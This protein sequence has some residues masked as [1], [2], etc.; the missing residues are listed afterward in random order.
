MGEDH[1]AV[2]EARSIAGDGEDGTF[3]GFLQALQNGR[4]ASTLRQSGSGSEEGVD[5]P[6]GNAAPLNFFRMFRFGSPSPARVNEN[7]LG[8]RA[9]PNSGQDG[10][11]ESDGRMVPII[12]V[13]IRSIN[14]GSGGEREDNIPPF[15]DALSSFPPNVA[16]PGEDMMDGMLR[17]PQNGT[18]FSHRR[19]ASM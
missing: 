11:D 19:R 8:D 6:G 14:P 18:R 5:T 4:I 3:D 7:R 16:A 17:Q 12:I 13:G 10:E 1:Q 9:V 15:L 2:A